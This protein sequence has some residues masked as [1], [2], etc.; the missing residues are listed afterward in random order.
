MHDITKSPIT[1]GNLMGGALLAQLG[2]PV[3]VSVVL[4]AFCTV[5]DR[6]GRIIG[7]FNNDDFVVSYALNTFLE[8]ITFFVFF[9]VIVK[10]LNLN[11]SKTCSLG[12]PDRKGLALP[13]ISLS[14][15]L[16]FA[17]ALLTGLLNIFTKLIFNAE[18]TMTAFSADSATPFN[19]MFMLLNAAIAPALI[20]EFAFRGAVIGIF[21]RYGDV[22]AVIIS[23]V[24]FALVHRNFV[25]IPYTLMFGLGLG[26]TRIITNSI[27]P[28]ILAHF[29]NNAILVVFT[30]VPSEYA[31]IGSFTQSA[32]LTLFAVLGVL[33]CINLRNK[34]VFSALT[35]PPFVKLQPKE[36]LKALFAPLNLIA[37]LVLLICAFT[38][39]TAV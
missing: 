30:F 14:L 25:Q 19:F 23:S 4:T 11:L 8:F 5:F 6:S 39:F 36:F 17:G 22:G 9:A 16:C 26:L 18:P 32:I 35:K 1:R 21:R 27:W 13:C 20:E 2:F 38:S 12:M 33:S 10:I 34:G 37:M 31:L 15:A 3:V 29:L 24:M 28:C 7:L